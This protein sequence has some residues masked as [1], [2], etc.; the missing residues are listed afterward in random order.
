MKE[1][2]LDESELAIIHMARTHRSAVAGFVH[3]RRLIGSTLGVNDLR[4]A[5][6]HAIPDYEK[7]LLIAKLA[8]VLGL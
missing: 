4:R 6:E 8:D 1:I 7:E 2:Q 3:V 5:A